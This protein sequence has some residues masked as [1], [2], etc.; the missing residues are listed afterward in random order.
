[1][2]LERL[3]V[4]VYKKVCMDITPER[5]K[6]RIDGINAVIEQFDSYEKIA[7]IVKMYLGMECDSETKEEFVN[8]FYEEDMT[9]DDQNT[10]EIA[11]LAGCTLLNLIQNN[12]DVQ[13][14]YSIKVLEP[15]YE[16]K[17]TELSEVASNVIATQTRVDK[18]IGTCPSLVW[19]KEWESEL[20]D[21]NG[22]APAGAPQV[23]VELMKTIKGQF[24]KVV[25][26]ANSLAAK[27][28]KCEEKIEVLSWIVG[29]W[30]DLLEKPLNEVSNVEGALIL[31]FELA[32]LVNMPGPFA[33]DALLN[34]MLTKCQNQ[35]SEIS[36]TELID[37]QTKEIRKY[38]NESCCQ[39]AEEKNL[40]IL[41]AIKASLTVEEKKEWVP[42]YKKKWKIDS[43]K[44][45]L[46]LREWAKLIYYE[47]LI[48][49]C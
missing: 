48:S 14:A 40:P 4:K 1:M 41:S 24:T 21:A 36:L 30:S 13:L 42:A 26:Y 15:F 31:G 5:I 33:A 37:S 3:F 6:S 32:E 16:G 11:I 7:E 46:T 29:E 8:C 45:M 38:I 17:V 27:N 20:V 23:T 39:E 44:E 18:Q 9:F 19:K 47:C 34:R 2:E 10:E 22:K 43:D 25:S 35:K 49:K 12:E 28:R